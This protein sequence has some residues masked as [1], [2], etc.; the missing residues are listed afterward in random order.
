[1]H[2]WSFWVWAHNA[3]GGNFGAFGARPAFRSVPVWMRTSPAFEE[4][5][6]DRCS[7]GS[8]GVHKTENECL[9]E[10][11]LSA[12]VDDLDAPF[13]STSA[14]LTDA[15][16]PQSCSGPFVDRSAT[17]M[18]GGKC[19]VFV[20]AEQSGRDVGS[21]R[22]AMPARAHTSAVRGRY[23]SCQH[24]LVAVHAVA[25]RTATALDVA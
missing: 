3:L 21:R 5:K 13:F 7:S 8:G 18:S 16:G 4:T 24:R 10:T 11:S 1:M 20:H 15:I 17:Q 9:W 23:E 25:R 6:C 12:Q 14:T 22:S 19:L 2:D